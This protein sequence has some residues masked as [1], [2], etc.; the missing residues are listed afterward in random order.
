MTSHTSSTAPCKPPGASPRHG[1]SP[2]G[3]PFSGFNLLP[4]KDLAA[5]GW[6]PLTEVRPP[7]T[8]DQVHGTPVYTIDKDQVTATYPVTADAPA[9]INRRTVE[10]RP[11]PRSPRTPP[12]SPW[13]HRPPRKPPLR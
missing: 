6:L 7:L 13:R 9:N 10:T 2:T 12:T 3:A 8:A 1:R 4:D 11:G 5:E